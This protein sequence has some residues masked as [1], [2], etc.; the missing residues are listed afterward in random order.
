MGEK[1]PPREFSENTSLR[2]SEQMRASFLVYS[3]AVRTKE[4]TSTNN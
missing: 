2:H 4:E 1:R 3:E